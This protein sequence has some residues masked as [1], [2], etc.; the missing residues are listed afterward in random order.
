M[1]TIEY[2]HGDVSLLAACAAAKQ[3]IQYRPTGTK[4]VVRSRSNKMTLIMT[5]T[6]DA[7]G[8]CTEETDMLSHD[9]PPLGP[10]QTAFGGLLHQVGNDDMGLQAIVINDLMLGEQI[11][12]SS[13]YLFDPRWYKIVN[14]TICAHPEGRKIDRFTR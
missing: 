14:N 13:R 2:D 5:F 4:C 6:V 12:K 9:K 7:N 8:N 3:L 10:A 1:I 11:S